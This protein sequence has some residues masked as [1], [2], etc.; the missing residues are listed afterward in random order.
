MSTRSSLGMPDARGEK[1]TK[2]ITVHVGPTL[3]MAIERLSKHECR[4][5]SD[6]VAQVVE[7]DPVVKKVLQQITETKTN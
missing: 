7:R 6:Y 5:V 2:P 4:T 3:A 1:R